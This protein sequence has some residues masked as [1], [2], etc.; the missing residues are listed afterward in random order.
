M[1]RFEF[2]FSKDLEG[3]FITHSIYPECVIEIIKLQDKSLWDEVAGLDDIFDFF[4]FNSHEG[5]QLFMFLVLNSDDID[6][7][8]SDYRLMLRKSWKWF[9]HGSLLKKIPLPNTFRFL[10]MDDQSD[11]DEY[12]IEMEEDGK[13]VYHRTYPVFKA[14]LKPKQDALGI[15]DNLQFLE[16]VKVDPSVQARIMSELGDWLSKNLY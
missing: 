11:Q 12:S 8:A 13:Y 4:I 3:L 16:E 15:I 7:E 9:L 10:E 14:K 5:N 1:N 6:D 2:K